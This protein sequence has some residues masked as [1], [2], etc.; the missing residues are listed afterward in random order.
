MI[1][2]QDAGPLEETGRSTTPATYHEQKEQKSRD[3]DFLKKEDCATK[4][5]FAAD[6]PL[7]TF[8]APNRER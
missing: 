2:H 3:P 5:T 1:R 4:A 6:G 7:R 8:V